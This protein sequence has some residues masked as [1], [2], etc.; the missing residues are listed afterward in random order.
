V[1]NSPEGP[2]WTAINPVSAKSKAVA[3]ISKSMGL[4][5]GWPDLHI[6]HRGKSVFIEFKADK[7]RVSPEQQ[8]LHTELATAGGF[9][10]IVQSVD[11][12]L[13]VLRFAGIPCAVL[14]S[15]DLHHKIILIDDEP[16]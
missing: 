14:T 13:D 12:F 10:G 3:G 4:R 1:P 11:Q 16:Q 9:V 7:G 8:Q 2:V 5:K 15:N 6:L